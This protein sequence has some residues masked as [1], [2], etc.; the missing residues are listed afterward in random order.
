[1][2]LKTIQNVTTIFKRFY[3]KP[4]HFSRLA[5]DTFS[6][7]TIPKAR[8]LQQSSPGRPVK[9]GGRNIVTMIP[10]SPPGPKLMDYVKDVFEA[11]H[12]PVDFEEVVLNGSEDDI[13]QFEK[14]VF[15]SIHRN[16]VAL[17]GN[18]VSP[19]LQVSTNVTLRQRLDLYVCVVHVK[20]YRHVK[21]KY[22]NMD[23]YICRQNTEGEYAMLEHAAKPGVVESLK[24]ITKQNTQRFA[25]WCFEFAM[26]ENRK[27][28]TIVHKANIMKL[29][30][31]LFL[32]TVKEVGMFYPKLIIDDMIVDNNTMQMVQNPEQFD[33]LV[34]PNLYG[35]ILSNVACGLIGGAGLMS[36]QNFG[37]GCALFEAGS[38]HLT[39]LDEDN[40]NP[41][42]ML[43]ASKDLLVY[44]G[45]YK[46]AKL[47]DE[48]I[49]KTLSDD[50]IQTHDIGGKHTS[51][52]VV[53]TV[54]KNLDAFFISDKVT[55][56]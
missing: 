16:G 41:I 45:H 43:N 29:S 26:K 51:D 55:Y 22:S 27:K 5:S 28:V 3:A 48:A 4:D 2:L 56:F 18:I 25:E 1:M 19:K 20:S 42:A 15:T 54:M 40:L 47:L 33:I 37:P 14:L 21:C 49:T 12:A 35:N 53:E 32:K 31:G 23:L 7:T 24:I 38:R 10:G 36:A 34:C 30:D 17:K 39:F 6:G 11:V 44:L 52:E 46:H 9:H 50:Q 13:R 8:V